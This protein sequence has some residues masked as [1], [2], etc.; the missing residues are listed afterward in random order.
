MSPLIAFR[1]PPDLTL[2]T[3]FLIPPLIGF[4][5]KPVPTTF[6]CFKMPLLILYIISTYLR[7]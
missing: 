7:L 3:T 6:V 2:F 1:F 4:W 5:F